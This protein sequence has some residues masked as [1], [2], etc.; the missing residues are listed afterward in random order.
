MQTD[1]QATLV[2]SVTVRSKL[3]EDKARDDRRLISVAKKRSA[4]TV[5]LS[6]ARHPLFWSHDAATQL[7]TGHL[8]RCSYSVSIYLTLLLAGGF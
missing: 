6:S 3:D 2:S 4:L 5:L 8:S 1:Q 7:L